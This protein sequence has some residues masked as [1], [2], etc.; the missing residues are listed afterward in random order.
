MQKTE[1]SSTSGWKPE[2]KH[3]QGGLK[4]RKRVMRKI[5]ILYKEE[6]I[7]ERTKKRREKRISKRR[8]Q[9]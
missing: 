8:R 9:R 5:K 6:R 2:I 3:S 4:T 7:S 1:F